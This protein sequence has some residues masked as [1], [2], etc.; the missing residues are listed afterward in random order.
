MRK[1]Q[2]LPRKGAAIHNK[3]ALHIWQKNGAILIKGALGVHGA[4]RIK[5]ALRVHGAIR[6]KGA[7]R[8]Y[9]AIRIKDALRVQCAQDAA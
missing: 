5:V 4:I 9:G 7:L 2:Y 1:T 3:G 6:I 8:V